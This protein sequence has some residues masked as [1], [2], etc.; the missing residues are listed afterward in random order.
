VKRAIVI[1]LSVLLALL[2]AVP[3]AF[4]HGGQ[5]SKASGKTAQLSVDWWQWALS[6]PLAKSPLVGSYKGG[7][8]CNGR[9]VSP[10]PGKTW[11]LAGSNTGEKVKRTCTVPDRPNLFF[12]VVNIVTFPFLKGETRQNQRQLAKQY[13]REVVNAPDFSMSVTVD[14]KELKRNRIDRA[15]SPV[16]SFTV[17][18]H[19]IFD[20]PKCKPPIDVPAGKYNDASSNGLWVTLQPLSKGKHKIHFEMSATTKTFGLVTQDNTYHLKVVNNRQT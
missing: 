19:N 1:A 6:K 17:A 20:C 4:G 18:E 12:P 2:V 11:F 13:I 9:P 5:G 16:F 8:E 15:L 7:P 10:T 14:G 3:M